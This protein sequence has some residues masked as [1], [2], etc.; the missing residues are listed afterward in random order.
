MRDLNPK[1]VADGWDTFCL[2]NPFLHLLILSAVF[3]A[4]LKIKTWNKK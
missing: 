4:F 1:V 3:H 2:K